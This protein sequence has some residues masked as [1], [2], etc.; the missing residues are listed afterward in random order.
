MAD[1]SFTATIDCDCGNKFDVP[2]AGEYPENIVIRCPACAAE[3][4]LYPE[5][6]A[7][8]REAEAVAIRK[9]RDAFKRFR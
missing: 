6:I 7:L 1:D 4:K 9:A 5:E 8:I 3:R 2:L